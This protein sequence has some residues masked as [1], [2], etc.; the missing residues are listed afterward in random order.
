MKVLFFFGTRPEA[1]KFAPL[2]LE[3]RKHQ[4]KFD[5][6]VCVSAQ[7]REMLN[8]VLTFFEIRPDFDLDIM[9]P[10]QNLNEIITRAIDGV[11]NVIKEFKPDLLFIQGDTTSTLAGALAAFYLGVKIAHVE[12]GLRS[13]D[14]YSPFPEEMNR[15]LTS[16]LADLH[17]APTQKAKKNL[18]K[19]L[20]PENKIHVVGN[21]GIDALFLCLEKIREENSIIPD[22]M[23][24]IDF[25]KKIILVTC[26]RR[27]SFG[28][29]F[30]KICNVLITI[31]QKNDVEI[32]YPVH[33]NPEVRKPAFRIL[34]G[35]K[36]IHLIEPLYYP[37]FVW[38]MNKAY[39]IM[40]DSG[41]I[42]EEAPSLGKP[43][44]VMR[45]VTERVEGIHIGTAKIVG[46][47]NDI[48]IN[49]TVKLLESK[50]EYMQM[51]KVRNPY[52][53]GKSCIKI[54]N[55]IDR[56]FEL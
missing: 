47:N 33:L 16:Q 14:K 50:K 42:Q 53:D 13:F 11:N 2:V 43:V 3:F 30:E 52:G 7:H 29:P 20:I 23:K 18:S 39:L 48:I 21:T 41:G 37:Q 8:Q 36:N 28:K 24:S 25:D 12:A 15:I 51:S 34:Y 40:T 31:A 54:R 46:T 10:S 6:K 56:Y 17:F 5:V 49:E 19:E 35:I 45:N 44:L 32:V 9:K 55:I 1:V 22:S 26:H 4:E 27:E 38:L